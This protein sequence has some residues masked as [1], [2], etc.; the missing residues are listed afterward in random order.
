MTTRNSPKN[1]VNDV[2]KNFIN[3]VVCPDSF[4]N[5]SFNMIQTDGI[6]GSVNIKCR[7]IP[8]MIVRSITQVL[9]QCTKNIA[10]II[11]TVNVTTRNSQTRILNS[12]CMNCFFRNK[13]LIAFNKICC[14]IVSLRLSSKTSGSTSY[15][16][17]CKNCTI[18]EFFTFGECLN[19]RPVF[20]PSLTI[21][22]IK[23]K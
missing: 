10:N 16:R 3:F 22:S 4:S 13:V 19:T 23:V 14:I 17:G 15:S 21:S 20:C 9:N 18:V 8:D 12:Q 5:F 2:L 6:S 7:S 11:F 1:I